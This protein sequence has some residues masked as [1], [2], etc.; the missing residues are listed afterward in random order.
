[1]I[2]FSS[3]IILS[4]YRTK[5]TARMPRPGRKSKRTVAGRAS[6]RAATRTGKRYGVKPVSYLGAADIPKESGKETPQVPTAKKQGTATAPRGTTG[7]RKSKENRTQNLKDENVMILQAA[8]NQNSLFKSVVPEHEE[9]KNAEDQKDEYT[10]KE[11]TSDTD[12]PTDWMK[13]CSESMSSLQD[14]LMEKVRLQSLHLPTWIRNH[15]ED[16][17]ELYCLP[18][19]SVFCVFKEI[20]EDMRD[21][22]E[23]ARLAARNGVLPLG[24]LDFILDD[25]LM[26]ELETNTVRN[27]MWCVGWTLENGMRSH[28]KFDKRLDDGSRVAVKLEECY[29]VYSARKHY[30][31]PMHPSCSLDRSSDDD[32]QD[33]DCVY[34]SREI[35]FKLSLPGEY[36]VSVVFRSNRPEYNEPTSDRMLV[37]CS[38]SSRYTIEDDASRFLMK[39]PDDIEKTI[40]FALTCLKLVQ[41]RGHSTAEQAP[42]DAKDE[43]QENEREEFALRVQPLSLQVRKSSNEVFDAVTLAIAIRP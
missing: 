37:S 39:N 38:W 6:S 4:V 11:E 22:P 26:N 9:A 17:K 2:I 8:T 10:A 13:M 34:Y 35:S 28:L 40:C 5:S 43:R 32:E 41:H 14:T 31:T 12:E 18:F 42:N 23:L 3:E 19:F 25:V 20:T 1:V 24:K 33:E 16:E 29:M 15:Y 7:G 21:V 30:K 36:S 27:E